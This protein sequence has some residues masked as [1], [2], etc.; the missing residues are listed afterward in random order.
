MC[1]L[2]PIQNLIE[3]LKS[4]FFQTFQESF[5]RGLFP[6]WQEYPDL[7]LQVHEGLI[8]KYLPDLLLQ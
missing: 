4:G 1:R 2:L 8:P 7:N 6:D 3:V 5:S